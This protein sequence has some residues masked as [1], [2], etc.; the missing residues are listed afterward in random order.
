MSY[1]ANF[2]TG[3]C[4]DATTRELL[5]FHETRIQQITDELRE[6]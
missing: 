5:G 6:K 4:I 3:G 2:A 1:S